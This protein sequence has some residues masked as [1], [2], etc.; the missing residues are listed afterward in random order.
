M[1]LLSSRKWGTI[2]YGVKGVATS[3][4]TTTYLTGNANRPAESTRLTR[5]SDDNA[6]VMHWQ[7]VKSLCEC[8]RAPRDGGMHSGDPTPAGVA[9]ISRGPSAATPPVDAARLHLDP[10][11][12]AAPILAC[13][14]GIFI[15]F[16][17]AT[18]DELIPI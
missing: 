14:V 6:Q 5:Y 4:L 11:G 2:S 16:I 15:C 1:K 13:F 10:G 17:A 7:S 12:V 8:P 3:S 9:A 18:F